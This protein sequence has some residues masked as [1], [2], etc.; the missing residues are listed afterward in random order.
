MTEPNLATSARMMR[1]VGWGTLVTLGLGF[2][3]Y[4]AG[5]VWGV[6]PPG[7]PLL[8]GDHPAS[9]YDG[10]HPYVWMLASLYLAWSILLIRGARDPMGTRS[11]VDFGILANLMHA[12]VMI[13]LA[14]TAPNEHAH[15]W[16]DVPLLLVIS[17]ILWVW[18]PRLDA[19]A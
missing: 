9:P 15:L 7:F 2:A 10:L 17:A 4:P 16:A 18:R 14:F 11:L 13:P 19:A 3:L 8:C 6:L 12:A 5:F 1:W